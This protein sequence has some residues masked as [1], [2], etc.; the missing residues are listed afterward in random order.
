M[1][2][3]ISNIMSGYGENKSP[4]PHFCELL[5][6]KNK[7]LF[8]VLLLEHTTQSDSKKYFVKIT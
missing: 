7:V 2:I 8:L 5:Y 1:L 4:S 6:M 3:H